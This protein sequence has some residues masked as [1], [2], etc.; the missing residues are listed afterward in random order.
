MVSFTLLP[1]TSIVLDLKSTPAAPNT[2]TVQMQAGAGVLRF[3]CSVVWLSWWSWRGLARGK[4]AGKVAA[5]WLQCGVVVVV[6]VARFGSRQA[7]R[8]AAVPRLH[9]IVE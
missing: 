3:G 7:G 8:G 9:G 2:V 6:A 5:G 1:A 4:Q